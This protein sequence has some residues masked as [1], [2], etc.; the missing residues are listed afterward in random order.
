M[1][2]AGTA[3]APR[4]PLYALFTG[5]LRKAL[6]EGRLPPGAVLLEG[7]LAELLKATRTPVRQALQQLEGEGLLSR[8][9]GR[10]FVVAGP[11]GCEA[12][13]LTLTHEMIGLGESR[14][15]AA[16]RKTRGWE[17]I[18]NTV[19]RDLVLL[20]VFGRFRVNELEM[21]RHYGVGRT[22]AHDVMLRLE[23]LGI[24]EQDERQR[25]ST[26]AL[27]DT[28]IRHLYEL[29]SLLE[30]VALEAAAARVPAT[31]LARKIDALR[32]AERDFEKISRGRM[33]EL[34]NELH[35]ELYQHGDKRDLLQVLKRTRCILVLSKYEFST[36]VKLPKYDA[37][38]GEH[39][40]VLQALV[41]GRAA[42][43]QELLRKHLE[44]SCQQLVRRARMLRET[45][46]RPALGY[47]D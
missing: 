41:D 40:Q 6:Y 5:L 12:Q 27:D 32:N 24:L 45:H 3:L 28:R 47:I 33:D 38:L 21:A 15:A 36:R 13:R 37:F 22:V 35:I 43:A 34:E 14:P 23:S 8:F 30:P 20:S 1:R 2:S 7:P 25:W 10:G 9:D 42:E 29:R 31:E 19:E 4:Q 16:P 11:P 44:Q 39:L 26:I 18:Y 17:T 46:G